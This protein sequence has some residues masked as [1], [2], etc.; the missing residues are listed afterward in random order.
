MTSLKTNFTQII[1][2]YFIKIKTITRINIKYLISVIKKNN[3]KNFSVGGYY[4][5]NFEIDDFRVKDFVFSPD[6]EI[7][8]PVAINLDDSIIVIS[9]T[10]IIE[11][12]LQDFDEV[13]DRLLWI[14]V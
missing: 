7:D 3:L 12:V 13:A 5:V 11:P 4:P 9:L 2:Y 8:V 1:I 14:W 10:A 6:S